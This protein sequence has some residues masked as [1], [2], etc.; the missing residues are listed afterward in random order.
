MHDKKQPYSG[1]GLIAQERSEQIYKHDFTVAKDQ[2]Y[3]SFYVFRK[4]AVAI[5]ECDWR[6]WPH[7]DIPIETFHKTMQKDKAGQ[8]TVAGALLAAEIDYLVT[9]QLWVLSPEPKAVNVATG[10]TAIEQEIYCIGAIAALPVTEYDNKLAPDTQRAIFPEIQDLYATYLAENE[11]F[12]KDPHCSFEGWL[13]NRGY[14]DVVKVLPDSFAKVEIQQHK[15]AYK[16]T[17]YV[18]PINHENN[19]GC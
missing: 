7:H 10:C 2:N 19:G 13:N 6:K 4:A 11:P 12:T 14:I 1:I 17:G 3:I 16:G 15:D 18:E 5:L 8:V 9:K